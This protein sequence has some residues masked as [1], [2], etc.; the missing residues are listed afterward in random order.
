M[1]LTHGNAQGRSQ[2][3][4]SVRSLLGYIL[5]NRKRFHS[6]EAL[7]GL[8]WGDM[9]EIHARNC[10]STAI[11]RLRRILEPDSVPRGTYLLT[12]SCGDVGFN[13]DSNYWL[14]VERLES[15]TRTILNHNPEAVTA[16]EVAA[17]EDCI[18]MY[19][20]D[21]LETCHED[22]AIHERER[23]RTLFLDGLS[24]LM[25]YHACHHAF[26]HSLEIGREI[27]RHDN[28]REEVH[29]C[30]MHLYVRNGERTLAVR[31]FEQCK[32][33]L[34]L[35]LGIEPMKETFDL[36]SDIMAARPLPDTLGCRGPS[37]RG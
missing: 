32:R 30:M 31:Q 4:K 35:E 21:V 37:G 12:S 14:D 19:C 7:A 1:H 20:G 8:L 22:W 9:D 10:L 16:E 5:I 23:I 29:R 33:I 26:A 25:R 3:P 6:R 27:L 15:C 34:Q 36:F 11:W 13:A 18:H 24:F 17:F 2:I 28:L